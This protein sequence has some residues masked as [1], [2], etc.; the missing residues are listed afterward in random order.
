MR[1]VSD[2]LTAL[3]PLLDAGGA[4]GTQS[5]AFYTFYHAVHG[6]EYGSEREDVEVSKV[7]LICMLRHAPSAHEALEG[8]SARRVIERAQS[9]LE[10]ASFTDLIALKAV[11]QAEQSA[12]R[13]AERPIALRGASELLLECHRTALH[14]G[15]DAIA[16][17][18]HHGLRG[19]CRLYQMV[20][21][22]LRA[23]RDAELAHVPLEVDCRNVARLVASVGVESLADARFSM[24]HTSDMAAYAVLDGPD[25]QPVKVSTSGA[26]TE[27]EKLEEV[28]KVRM[29]ETVE[30]TPLVIVTDPGKDQDDE[31]ALILSRA[32]SDMGLVDVCA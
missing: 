12:A 29:D 15:P 18:V 23:R 8:A 10:K 32:L 17:A 28:V 27:L 26:L 31:L 14:G 3:S 20:S 19:I 5:E 9:A 1:L 13:Q 7:R 30:P 24:L 22:S 4:E 11:L 6:L 2:A 25:D 21:K 16:D